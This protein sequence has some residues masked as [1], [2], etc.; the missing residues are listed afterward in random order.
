MICEV[1]S[2]WAGLFADLKNGHHKNCP[3]PKVVAA[4]VAEEREACAKVAEDMAAEYAESPD[5]IT[6]G[7]RRYQQLAC[8]GTSL[9]GHSRQGDRMTPEQRATDVREKM[10]EWSQKDIPQEA[11]DEW[12]RHC[13]AS[14]IKD[15]VKEEREACAKT[16]EDFKSSQPDGTVTFWGDGLEVIRKGNRMSIKLTAAEAKKLGLEGKKERQ[17]KHAWEKIEDQKSLARQRGHEQAM[18]DRQCEVHG[19]PILDYEY[20]F[21]E[22]VGRKFRFDYL[23]DGWLAVEKDGGLYGQGEA[24]P[25]CGRKAVEGAFLHQ[26]ADG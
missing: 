7:L 4:A 19:L 18:F 10:A 23:F 15:A 12:V 2:H 1:C 5:I 6:I 9:E 14:H 11:W 16:V 24:C 17:K 13:I 22:E 8:H 26:A 25:T 20:P 3:V 21:A